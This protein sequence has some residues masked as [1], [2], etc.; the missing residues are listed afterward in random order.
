MSYQKALQ[1]AVNGYSVIPLRKDKRPLLT[2]WKKHQTERASED[3]VDKWFEEWPDANYGIVTGKIS[4]ITVVDIDVK[5]DKVTPLDT[6]PET[7][8]VKTPSG[9]YH[10]YYQYDPSIKQTANTFKQFPHVDIRNDGGY[11]VGPGSTGYEVVKKLNLS[12]FPQSLFEVKETGRKKMA[13]GGVVA[14]VQKTKGMKD[15]DGRNNAMTSLL[16]TMLKGVPV[17]Q[18]PAVKEAFM[19][20]AKSADDPLPKRELETIWK[21]IADRAEKQAPGDIDFVVNA[22]G[23]PYANLENIKKVFDNDE[24]FFDRVVF[25]RFSQTHLYKDGEKY[26]DLHDTDETTIT[27]ELSVKYPFFVTVALEKVRTVMLEHARE[28]SI[29]MAEDW[30]RAE[31]WDGTPRLDSWLHKTYNTPDDEYHQAVGSNWLKG[32]A[33]R[34]IEPGCKFDYVL[35]LEGEQGIKKSTSL[36]ILGGYWHVE[37]TITPDN[38]DF[39]MLLQGNLIIEFSE[40]ETLSRGEIKQLKAVITAQHDKYRAPYERT[41]QS[42][43]RRCV[44]AMTTN[45]DEYLKD[46]T[47]NRRW[48]PVRCIGQVNTDWLEENRAQLLAEALHRVETLKET[49]WEFPACVVEEQEKRRIYDPNTERI[50]DWYNSAAVT[51]IQKKAG[52]TIDAVWVGAFGRNSG[53]ANRAEQMQIATILVNNLGLERKRAMSHGARVYR[54][55]DPAVFDLT[56]GKEVPSQKVLDETF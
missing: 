55:F 44:F 52:I 32:M 18:Y 4:G 36:G 42:H 21:S 28:H 7:F 16:G 6:F 45:Q 35:V 48:L 23:V 13:A 25:D 15:G 19:A 56:E 14:K 1:Y 12:K 2:S 22:N 53:S 27:R 40:G 29:D 30:I 49:T 38:K 3:E 31:K 8:T 46:E 47:G 5:G 9:G 51:D 37:T 20:V 43:P 34:V 11:V 39:F 10:L 54:Y 24:D 26:R 50:I 41:I 17:E 33:K